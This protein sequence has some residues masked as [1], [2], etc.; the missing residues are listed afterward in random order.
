MPPSLLD[1][2][3]DRGSVRIAAHWELTAEQYLDPDT[4]EPAG[5][6]GKV[7]AI[8][9][10]DLGVRPDFVGLTWDGQLPALLASEVDICLKHTNTPERAFLVD[11]VRGR[12]E[13][14]EGR[15]VV[16]RERGWREEAEL[17]DPGRVVAAIGGSHQEAQARE[18]YPSAG[19]L[20][21]ATEHDGMEAVRRGD[22]DACLGDAWVPNFLRLRPECDVLR[23][24]DGE[25]I[26]TSLDY[27]HP[28]IRKGD[29]NFLNWLD[30]WMDFHAV[31]GS[32][33]RAIEDAY[34]EHA[35]KADTILASFLE[36]SASA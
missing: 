23:R 15:I 33:E 8:L 31:Q 20:L 18:R 10:R 11:F 27:G 32:F 7:G 4:G 19:V 16:R 25:P 34:R 22:A 1:T 9:A 35:A 28:C 14:Y 17:D 26:R 29:P 13:R 36:R 12:L 2:I 24:D 21:V 30:N 6:V 3:T 5:V